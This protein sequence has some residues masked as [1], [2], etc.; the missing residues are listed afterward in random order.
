MLDFLLY[1]CGITVRDWPA[2]ALQLAGR[3]AGDAQEGFALDGAELAHV[4]FVVIYMKACGRRFLFSLLTLCLSKSNAGSLIWLLRLQLLL[5]AQTVDREELRL[6]LSP[7]RSEQVALQLGKHEEEPERGEDVGESPE[8]EGDRLDD[9][10]PL[11]RAARRGGL[12]GRFFGL[13]AMLDCGHIGVSGTS[14]SV[15]CTS[16]GEKWRRFSESLAWF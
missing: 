6:W 7:T 16:V 3:S 4:E 10:C 15:S 5:C 11:R 2:I 8:R 13:W 9:G 14:S 1:V 12:R